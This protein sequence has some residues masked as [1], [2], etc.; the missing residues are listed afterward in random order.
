M[1]TYK[2]VNVLEQMIH[3]FPNQLNSVIVPY[4]KYNYT[5]HVGRYPV[6]I[7]CGCLLICENWYKA[8]YK[9]FYMTF[10]LSWQ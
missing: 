6:C 8:Q 10:M 1:Q 4:I 5:E 9:H 2:N 7:C 3:G